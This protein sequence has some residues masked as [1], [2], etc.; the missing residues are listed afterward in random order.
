[1]AASTSA[2]SRA[3]RPAWSCCSSTARTTPKPS[4]IVALD[5]VANRTYHYWH[6]F[7]PGVKPGQLYG[8]RV[9]G[10]NEPASG[11]A[12]RPDQG[13]ARPVRPRRGRAEGLHARRR[14]AAG[15]QRRDR[16]EERGR[17][18]VRL[19]LG[20]RRAAAAAV[21]PHGHLRDARP[22]VHPPPQLRRQGADPRHLRRPGREDPVPQGSRHH[23]GR[24]A[25]DPRVRR[26]GLPAG[27]RQLLGLSARLVLR[28]APA[29]QL[30]PRPARPGGRVPRHGE[31]P[32]PGGHRGDPRRGVQ[33]HRRGQP[34]R[35]D[36]LL[37]R[38]RQPDL[39]H[40]RTGRR[41][42]RGLL[43]LRQHA[44]RQPPGRPA[45][46]RGQ[47]AVLGDRD[48]RG[49][50]PVRPRVDPVARLERATRCR[51]RRCCGTSSRTR[52]WP[53]PS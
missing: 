37:P 50:V 12:V 48:A 6:T 53:A 34:R 42:V 38:D 31:G 45:D 20:G 3:P 26:P 16:D 14:P 32:P 5:P 13:A 28:A 17:G 33:P 40:P 27:A 19:R 7:V 41:A 47:P 39:L 24:V 35:A 10:P 43:R 25:A 30:A 44:Q 1:M 22:R 8:Y 18:S 23:R 11:L 29:V 2:C 49:R 52:R 15:R 46:D 4:R 9:H 36:A 51:T 21:G